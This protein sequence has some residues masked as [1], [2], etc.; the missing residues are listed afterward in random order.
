MHGEKEGEWKFYNEDGKL[1]RMG[2]YKAQKEKDGYLDPYDDDD[3][4]DDECTQEMT[5][6]MVS[7]MSIPVELGCGRVSGSIMTIKEI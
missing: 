1:E 3:D 7:G 5:N 2:S 4:N 6:V